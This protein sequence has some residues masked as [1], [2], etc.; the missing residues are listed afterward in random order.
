M[1]ENL[2]YSELKNVPED[3]KT[4]AWA[5]LHSLYSSNAEL[6]KKLGVATIAV[7]NAVKKYV[8]NEP[9]GRANKKDMQ[10]PE[11]EVKQ[12]SPVEVKPKR[13][14]NRKAKPE[15]EKEL[16]RVD[17]KPETVVNEVPHLNEDNVDIFSISVKK[18]ITGED[19]KTL[20]NGIG[21]TLLK[22]QRYTIEVKVIEG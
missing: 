20:L 11:P 17:S 1:Y 22:D 2:S 12:E 18:D 8:L 7:V 21:S 15:V 5:E 6:A 16:V 14:Y 10:K 9:I 4:E 19:A 3:K 13:K